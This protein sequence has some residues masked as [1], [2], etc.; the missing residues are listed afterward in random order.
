[1][2]S[3]SANACQHPDP[4]KPDMLFNSFEFAL[5]LPLVVGLYWLLSH[6]GQNR[7]LLGASYFFYGVWDWRF[8]GLIALSTLVDFVAGRRI[9]GLTQQGATPESIKWRKLWVLLS[10]T[11]NLSVLA[12]FKYFNFF[13]DSLGSLLAVWGLSVDLP[14]LAIVLPVGISFYTFQTISYS[15]DVYRGQV[16]P[17][18][19]LLDF[20]LFVSFFPQL[21][22]GPIERAKVLLPQVLSPRVF[23]WSTFGDGI[24]LIF[25]GL[26]MK[27][28]VADNLALIV[29]RQFS[30]PNVSGFGALVG[31][32]AFAFQIYGDFAGYSKVARGCAMLL[33]FRLMVNFRH[34]YISADPSEFWR[35]W[36]I[37]LSTWLRDYLYI[38]LGGN[39]GG[40]GATYRNLA[41]TMLLGGLWHGASWLFVLWGAYQ[42]ILLMGHRYLK[43]VSRAR[44]MG[45]IGRTLRVF[46]MFQLICVGWLIF[47]AHSVSQVLDMLWAVATMRGA[48]E[49][50]LA[51]S[52]AGFVAPLLVV[53]CAQLRAGGEFLHRLPSIHVS[54][55]SAVFAILAYLL[56]FHG[57]TSQSFIY[58]QF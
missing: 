55:K 28:F 42:G 53:E 56:V 7:L 19:N 16:Q 1:L 17:A 23:S 25:W 30:D 54:L 14:V 33:G 27:V 58:F 49:W 41:T 18:E 44:E 50:I 8:L 48:T 40:S 6:R 29:D 38:P 10:V 12:C 39:R 57:A 11:V 9:G 5:F 45:G 26:F 24:A 4:N 36:H 35:R 32:Y 20:A 46:L 34:P 37:S 31:V 15:V 13:I 21:V 2:L 3:T 47:R 22:A 43:E 51:L 52:V